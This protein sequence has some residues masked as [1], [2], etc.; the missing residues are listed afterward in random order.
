MRKLSACRGNRRGDDKNQLDAIV[1]PTGGVTA[2]RSDLR[3]ARRRRKLVHPAMVIPTSP[4]PCGRLTGC[5]WESHFSARLLRA[6]DPD[7]LRF[8]QATKA[9]FVPH[10]IPSIG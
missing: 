4:V 3:R 10:F 8:E 5:R 2:R 9:R 7:R 6:G 1:A